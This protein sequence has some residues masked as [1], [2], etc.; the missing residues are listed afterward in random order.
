MEVP[1]ASTL[2]GVFGQVCVLVC[3][4]SEHG[5]VAA[6]PVL[7]QHALDVTVVRDNK[8]VVHLGYAFIEKRGRGG[9]PLVELGTVSWDDQHSVIVLL[10]LHSSGVDHGRCRVA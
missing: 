8:L 1:G 5:G 6:L 7:Y 4:P 10:L 9:V 3:V 2:C